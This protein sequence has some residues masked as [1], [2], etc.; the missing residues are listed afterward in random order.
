MN[1]IKW[2]R[3]GIARPRVAIYLKVLAVFVF[4]SA[5]SHLASIMG[6]TGGPWVNKPWYFR[7]ADLLLLL[8]NPVV[9]WGLWRTRFWGVVAWVAAVVFLQAVPMLLL[10]QFSAPDPRLRATWY[11]M[12]AVHAVML[13]AFLLLLPRTKA[14]SDL[15]D[16]ARPEEGVT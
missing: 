2:V 3:D 16:R 1:F 9:A 11:G 7:T 5:F 15:R 4:L 13:G 8:A 10:I 6:L 12:L 14:G